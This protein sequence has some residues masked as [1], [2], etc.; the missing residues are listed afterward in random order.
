MFLQPITNG[1]RWATTSLYDVSIPR[2]PG[3]YILN[4]PASGKFYIG[5]TGN[6][7]QRE[8][9]LMTGLNNG[10]DHN[11]TLQELYW[12]DPN[13]VYEYKVARDRE[14]AYDI[15][16]EELNKWLGHPDCLNVNNDA[17]N[18]WS[19]GTMPD[20]RRRQLNAIASRVQAGKKWRLGHNNS[21]EQRQRQSDSARAAWA[22]RERV[23][24]VPK[25][26]SIDGVRYGHAGEAASALGFS[27]RTVVVRAS[28]ND[29]RYRNWFYT[30]S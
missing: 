10:R 24:T 3:C 12:D 30:D 22:G 1:A 18:V 19:R 17:R 8:W 20:H 28:G 4:H 7:K 26:L 11:P 21:D 29:E 27:R 16:Q 14:E 15:E 25:A 23:K 5:S 13:V 6:L 2:L 9:K